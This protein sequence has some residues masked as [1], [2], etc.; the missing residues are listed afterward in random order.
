MSYYG[1]SDYCLLPIPRAGSG[2]GSSLGLR[3]SVSRGFRLSSSASSVSFSSRHNSTILE[4]S[5]SWDTARAI[6]CHVLLLV[7]RTGVRVPPSWVAPL[8]TLLPSSPLTAGRSGCAIFFTVS[9]LRYVSFV[10]GRM[11][12]I[13]S[14]PDQARPGMAIKV[15]L[16]DLDEGKEKV[17]SGLNRATRKAGRN[18]AT[19]SDADFLY[20]WIEKPV[21]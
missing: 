14:D 17:R 15:P 7:K 4:G 20:V 5:A 8:S 16:A 3:T 2:N 11:T 13:L 21:A 9:R 1:V 18:V 6:S 10:L 12:Q 19:A